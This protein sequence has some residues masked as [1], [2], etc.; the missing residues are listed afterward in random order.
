MKR[1]L[2]L[3]VLL[4]GACAA[5]PERIQQPVNI[6]PYSTGT[7][8]PADFGLAGLVTAS[9]PLP[10]PTP[11][12]YTVQAGDTMGG[13]ALKFGVKLEDLQAANPQISAN[14]MSIGQ[15]LRIP[16]DPA[17][18]S[19]EPTPVPAPLDIQQIQCYPG[20]G[21]SMWCAVLVHN[22]TLRSLR[23][24]QRAGDT[25]QRGGR[26]TCKRRRAAAAQ[27]PASRRFSAAGYQF[28]LRR[29]MRM[30]GLAPRC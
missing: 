10:S 29:P 5:P 13:V 16:S 11:F 12:T 25:F 3:A 4:A 14:S 6:V 30:P 19:G 1:L 17:N 22:P 26:T 28:F 18:P 21:G 24:H 23:E 8:A 7:P 20:S 15:V 2:L 9:V 27:Y